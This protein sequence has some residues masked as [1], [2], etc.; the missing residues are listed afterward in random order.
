MN[1]NF[2]T[3]ASQAAGEITSAVDTA[4]RTLR[5]ELES[6]DLE[7]ILHDLGDYAW[8]GITSSDPHRIPTL[9]HDICIPAELARGNLTNAAG[10]NLISKEAAEVVI[11]VQSAANARH[12]LDEGNPVTIEWLAALANVSERTVRTATSSR[13]PNAIPITKEGHWTLIQA[14]HAL[15]WLS[16]RKDFVPT[17]RPDNRPTTPG[18]LRAARPGEA[19]KEWRESRNLTIAV[20]ARELG[21]T[22]DQTNAYEKF[23]SAVPDDDMITLLPDFWRQLA[24]H[25]DSE[26]PDAVAALTFRQ[27]AA[28]YAEWQLAG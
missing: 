7:T 8:S 26:E 20:I 11:R 19:W 28:A 24:A 22:S 4:L 27:L 14:P 9:L 17:Q 1:T 6:A 2:R 15:E 3:Q 18:L 25:L 5:G 12:T 23:E 21:W 10:D 16:K 13:N